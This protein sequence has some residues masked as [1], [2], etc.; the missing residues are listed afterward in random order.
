M[1]EDFDVVVTGGEPTGICAAN[2]R[3]RCHVIGEVVKFLRLQFREI[4]QHRLR[5]ENKMP[6]VCYSNQQLCAELLGITHKR[7]S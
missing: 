4:P 1:T 3:P 6:N 7:I 5:G 2:A